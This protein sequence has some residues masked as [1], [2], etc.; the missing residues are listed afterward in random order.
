M[1]IYVQKEGE[2]T[3]APVAIVMTVLVAAMAMAYFM[4]YVPPQNALPATRDVIVTT[5]QQQPTIV[6]PGAPGPAGPA[7][8][9]GAP[10]AAG[11]AGA[12]GSSEP[13][14]TTNPPTTSTGTSGD[15][16]T[17]TGGR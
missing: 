9:A 16:S 1:P 7:G 2:S 4:W 11:A 5:P 8:A 17:S 10:G 12:A 13:P 15:G 14:P 3:W 6:V